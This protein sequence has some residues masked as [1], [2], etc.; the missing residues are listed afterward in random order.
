MNRPDLPMNGC[1]GWQNQ[2]QVVEVVYNYRRLT[3]NISNN[4]YSPSLQTMD[5]PSSFFIYS[6]LRTTRMA[7]EGSLLNYLVGENTNNEHGV[8]FS[9]KSCYGGRDSNTQQAYAS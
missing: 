5:N 1:P 3:K 4:F 8:L 7:V 6:T 9:Q 2:P